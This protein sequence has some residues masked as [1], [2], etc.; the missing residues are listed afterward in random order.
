LISKIQICQIANNV[1]FRG[2]KVVLSS[3]YN[4]L[5]QHNFL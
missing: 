1:S 5:V 2:L 4:L 3:I